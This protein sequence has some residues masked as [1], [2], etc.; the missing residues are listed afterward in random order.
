M[1]DLI[2]KHGDGSCASFGSRR[3]AAVKVLIA[4]FGSGLIVA[5]GFPRG[6]TD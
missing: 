6:K 1:K 4:P 2:Q 5:G 3:K